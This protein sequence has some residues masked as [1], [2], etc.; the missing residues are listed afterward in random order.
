MHT[1]TPTPAFAWTN[2]KL[3]NPSVTNYSAS[4]WS[5][6]GP[7]SSNYFPPHRARTPWSESSNTHSN[8]WARSW[9]FGW[10]S[11]WPLSSQGICFSPLPVTSTLLINPLFRCLLWWWA[12]RCWCFM[13]IWLRTA[14]CRLFTSVGWQVLS[15]LFFIIVLQSIYI[16]IV[17]DS[18][19]A[20]TED[21]S[22]KNNQKDLESGYLFYYII[23][24]ELIAVRLE[25]S[26]YRWFWLFCRLRF[27]TSFYLIRP[28]TPEE[29]SRT[30]PQI[31]LKYYKLCASDW[32]Y[33]FERES[34]THYLI[35]SLV[36]TQ[37][38]GL[39]LSHS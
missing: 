12:T 31:T 23:M 4:A 1:Q 15:I 18:Y 34:R 5:W 28:Y 22:E 38:V 20:V 32:R 35:G 39:W 25:H 33:W 27:G 8:L 2:K 3:T 10:A 29:N 6:C 36:I 9:S 19:Y 16:T 30:R 11:V 17:T 21:E 14:L 37:F 24:Y 7:Q 13:G 26:D